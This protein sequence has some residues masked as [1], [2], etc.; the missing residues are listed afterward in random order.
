MIQKVSNTNTRRVPKSF[1]LVMSGL[2]MLMMSVAAYADTY[3]FFF[4]KKKKGSELSQEEG[5]SSPAPETTQAA[6]A[7]TPAPTSVVPQTSTQQIT[8]PSGQP[9]IINN[10]VSVPNTTTVPTTNTAPPAAY[11]QGPVA[12]LH[13]EIPPPMPVVQKVRP[14][15]RLGLS[16]IALKTSATS[17]STDM[18]NWRSDMDWYGYEGGSS[19][20]AGGYLL[21]LGYRFEPSIGVNAYAGKVATL[22]GSVIGGADF[23]WLPLR[24]NAGDWDALELGL[25]AGFSNFTGKIDRLEA[26]HVGARLNLNAGPHFSLTLAG[27]GAKN[28]AMA[29]LGVSVN[30]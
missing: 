13:A 16:T 8:T 3:N 5:E 15:W 7:P 6:P 1:Y 27:K 12:G 22:G 29:E 14:A 9:L 23:E 4:D 20:S 28:M 30:L 10:T 18:Y 24:R 21:S 25:L 19:S 11:P 17:Q 26:L 2:I